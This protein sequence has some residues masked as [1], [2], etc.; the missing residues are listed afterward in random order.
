MPTLEVKR[1][2]IARRYGN[3]LLSLAED[4]KSV[5]T[6]QEDVQRLYSEIMKAPAVWAQ[7]V[8][9]IIPLKTQRGIVDKLSS[10]LKLGVLL[11]S[12]LKVICQHRRLKNLTSI[13]EE[14][15]VQSQIAEGVVKG[16]V[17][18]AVELPEKKVKELQQTLKKMLNKDVVLH[19]DVK[20]SLLGG[21]I[22]RI[23]SVMIDSSMQTQL[24]KLQSS[25]KG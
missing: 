9:P 17:E 7:G 19:Q 21:V 23:G 12:F 15:I 13:L 2:E 10:S 14:F 1:D 25:M 24:K 18:T 11:S 3:V 22:V 20:E 16:V 6:L 8:S 4:K 5:A